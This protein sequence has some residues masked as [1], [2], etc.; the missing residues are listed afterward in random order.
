MGHYIFAYGSNLNSADLLRYT[1]ERGL[2]PLAPK[3]VC[4]AK[5]KNH[6]LSWT[7]Y[8]KTRQCGVLNVELTIDQEVWGTVFDL[9]DEELAVFDRKEGHPKHYLR[10][11]VD[12]SDENNRCLKVET[13]IA[14][15]CMETAYLYPSANYLNVVLDG[16]KEQ[17]L[18]EKYIN[19][20]SLRSPIIDLKPY[21]GEC[22]KRT[23]I[24]SGR[25]A[26]GK[27]LC[28][29]QK[30]Y[31]QHDLGQ[32][33]ILY[34]HLF[35]AETL[36]SYDL[37]ILPGGDSKE[38]CYGLGDRGKCIV[39]EY[40]T[41]GGTMLGVCAGAY[42]TTH[43][44]NTY[45]GVSPFVVADYD[46]AHRGEALLNIA[47]TP[48]GQQLFGLTDTNVV[49]IIYHNGPTVKEVAMSNCS[50]LEILAV[51]EEELMIPDCVPLMKGAPAAWTNKYGNGRVYALSPHI[52]R[53]EG[54]EY[55]MANFIQNILSQKLLWNFS[56]NCIKS[57]ATRDKK[58]RL[59]N[60]CC[61]SWLTC[62]LKSKMM[63]LGMF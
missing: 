60:S 26:K 55:L 28:Y 25:G 10:T 29:W 15:P 34:S 33:D 2:P 8:S 3:K 20:F 41:N 5:M 22:R 27:T 24:Y 51:F 17:Q 14:P 39:R 21:D 7:T 19:D 56:N 54:K 49:P 48:K 32:L 53:T 36:A 11:P 58:R 52:E 62:P 57:I 45:M 35:T 43:Q 18:P 46:H 59:G 38:I 6:L 1:Q 42:A 47:F 30:I 37:L 61:S 12:V 63:N 31:I 9:T 4:N 40:L 23:A 13:Y 44:M 16:M 50:D